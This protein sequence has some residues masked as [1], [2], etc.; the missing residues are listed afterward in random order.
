M[1]LA[2]L[3]VTLTRVPTD[4]QLRALPPGVRWLEV[5]ADLIGDPD[6][7]ELERLRAGG[8]GLIYTLRSRAESGAGDDDPAARAPRLAAAAGRY[9]RIDLEGDR[10]GLPEVLAAVPPER[11]IVSWHGAAAAVEVLAEQLL[12]LRRIPAALYKLVPAAGEPAQASAPLELLRAERAT[13][14]TAFA[15][16]PSGAWTRPLAPRLGA[17]VVYGALP[18]ATPGA[19]GQLGV[20]RLVADFGL[21]ELP[22][23]EAVY[24]VVGNPVAQSLSP[25][26]HNAAYRALG[27][28]LL[29][30]PFHTE[31]FGDFWLEVVEG[32][33]LA[34]LGWPL[35]GLAVTAPYKEVALAVAGAASP[36]AGAIGAANTLVH[37]DGVWEAESTDPEGVLEPLRRRGVVLAGLEVAV[38]GAGGAGR[39]AVVGL[40]G[41]GA[42]VTLV[43][44]DEERGRHTAHE[45]GVPFRPLAGFDPAGYR[46]LVQ[47]TSLGRDEADPLPFDPARLVPGALVVDLVYGEAPTPLLA[48]VAARGRG[49]V[50]GR[51]V[52]L[53]QAAG[54]FQCMTG[55]ALPRAVAREALGLPAEDAESSGN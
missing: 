38:L 35:G 20:D 22:P 19:P 26:L 52:L 7:S 39:A 51:E 48:A 4:A 33:V 32:E 44:R 5:R 50:D 17:P 24:G 12:R 13:D 41:A 30:L 3:I 47:A 21:P 49:T 8:A 25:R 16:G 18:G 34:S 9:D 27:L 2:E 23:L 10:D 40:H 14:V 36:R 29:F 42:R 28:P 31:H 6:E 54:Q 11:R 55:Q 43:N 1:A 15:S 45:L 37:H 53:E 46:V